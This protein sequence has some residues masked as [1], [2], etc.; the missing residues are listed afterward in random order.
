MQSH[1]AALIALALTGASVVTLAQTQME[2]IVVSASRVERQLGQVPMAVSLVNLRDLQLG[3]QELGLDES[4]MRVPGLFMQNRYNFAQDLR[5]SIRG[6]GARASFGMRGIKVFTDGIPVTLP[7]GQSGTDDLDIGS[8][9][10]IEV[11]RGPAASLYG[12]ASGGVISVTTE[13][14]PQDPFIETR[15]TFGDYGHRKYQA[16]LGGSAG[17]LGYLVN[18]S[19]MEMDGYRD[20]SG[21]EHRLINTKFTYELDETADLTVIAS[22]VDSPRAQD[23]GGVTRADAAADRRGAQPRNTSSAAGEAFEQQRLG[24][25]YNKRIGEKHDLTLRSYSLWKDFRTFIPI[26][27]HIPFVPDD[28]VVQFDREHYGAGALYTYTDS[29]AGLPNRFSLG[30]D[31]DV[32]RDDRQRFI[33]NAGVQGAR[34]FDQLEKAESLGL[35]FRNETEFTEALTLSVGGRLDSLDLSID[36]RYLVNGDQ[37]GGIDFDEFSPAVGLMWNLSAALNLYGNYATSFETPTFTELGSPAQ[38]LNV[39]LGGFNNVGAQEATSLEIGAKGMLFGDR[40]FYDMAAY[41]MDVEDEI[42]NV[43]SIA[44]RAFFENADTDRHGIEAQLQVQLTDQLDLT[45]AYTYSDFTFDS[46]DGKPNAVGQRVPGIPKHLFYAELAYTRASGFFAIWDMQWV[47]DFYADN[48]NA[49]KVDSYRV[50]NVRLGAERQLGGVTVAPFFGINN[51]FDEDYFSNVR[52]NA[53]GGRA[54]EPAPERHVYG[55]V[56]IRF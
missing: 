22:A 48:A 15:F 35:Y 51:L 43:V 50:S 13:T 17:N 37:S 45:G 20:F 16:K 5:V 42:S 1:S 56:R 19:H 38:D 23:P 36:D 7:D 53:F 28:G 41:T 2:E 4:L 8:A 44:N 39:N 55:G 49:D 33:N 3:R 32:Q 18:V 26:G 27:S 47:G 14:P 54:F 21:V 31:V 46:F 10:R 40:V 6:F 34:V 30:V 11:I 24:L 52:V 9:E 12:T 29:L 25:V